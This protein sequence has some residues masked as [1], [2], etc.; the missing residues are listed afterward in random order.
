[1]SSDSSERQ[2]RAR[3]LAVHRDD[4]DVEGRRTRSVRLFPAHHEEATRDWQVH[5]EET[6]LARV[7]QSIELT[8]V[9]CL[10]RVRQLAS[11]GSDR[12]YLSRAGRAAH[13]ATTPRL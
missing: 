8:G 10:G 1:M 12:A 13:S 5:F 3:R 4:I 11:A 2:I 7:L 9:G 6:E